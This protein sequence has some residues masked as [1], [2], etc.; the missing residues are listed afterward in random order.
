[1]SR[2]PHPTGLMM[3]GF[4]VVDLG[5]PGYPAPDLGRYVEWL[6]NRVAELLIL[7]PGTPDAV[8]AFRHLEAMCR[9][10]CHERPC[11]YCKCTRKHEQFPD[12]IEMHE[13]DCVY[14]AAQYFLQCVGCKIVD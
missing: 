9:A 13:E 6:R 4:P 11:P 14:K 8:A 5:Y 3:H 2:A 10:I 12:K 7:A 1:M